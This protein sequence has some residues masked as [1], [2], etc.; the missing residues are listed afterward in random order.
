[1]YYILNALLGVIVYCILSNSSNL[2]FLESDSKT[3]PQSPYTLIISPEVLV[4]L[5]VFEEQDH[6]HDYVYIQIT[7][8]IVLLLDRRIHQWLTLYSF[9]K[10]Y[11]RR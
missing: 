4:S 3:N 6:K 5:K 1:M 10:G 8:A 9:G 7:S 2:I 11:L